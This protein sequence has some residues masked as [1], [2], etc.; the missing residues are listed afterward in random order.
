MAIPRRLL[1]ALLLTGAL[2][3]GAIGA[4][5]LVR[6]QLV[7]KPAPRPTFQVRGRVVGMYPGRVRTMKVR[8]RNPHPFPIRARIGDGAPGCRG[9]YLRVRRLRT[10]LVIKARSRA[11]THTRVVLRKAAPDA[12]MGARFPLTFTGKA[13]RA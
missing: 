2:V 4:S 8:I 6:D 1:A 5:A 3:M 10:P 11:R 9:G 12:C 7:E 13:V